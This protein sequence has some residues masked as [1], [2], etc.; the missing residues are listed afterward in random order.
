ML[1]IIVAMTEDRV[2]GHNN[3]MPWYL[4]ADL[5][6]FKQTTM[7]K[8]IVMGR[9]THDSIGK[10]LFGR[11]NIILSRNQQL[12]YKNCQVINNIENI[13]TL[14]DKEIMIIGGAEIY[15]LLLPYVEYLYITQVHGKFTGNT[16]FPKINWEEWQEIKREEHQS[17]NKNNCAYN[18]LIYKRLNFS[19]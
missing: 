4:P 15:E 10:A 2:I 17:D 3:K 7:G 9:K 12:T 18:F 5:K 1:S 16:Y 13:L 8:P 11:K 19:I 6:Y 14:A